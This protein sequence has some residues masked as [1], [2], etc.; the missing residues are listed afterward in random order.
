[1][2]R[3]FAE[4][5]LMLAFASGHA[6]AA[7]IEP[8]SCRNGLFPNEQDDLHV[9]NVAGAKEERLAFYQD[10]QGCPDAGD[11][12]KSKAYVLPGDEVIVNKVRGEWACAWFAGKKHETVGW[13][14]TSRLTSLPTE[15]PKSLGAWTGRWTESPGEG[16]IEITIVGAKLHIEGNTTWYGGKSFDGYPVVHTGDLDG[17]MS[18]Q[19]NMAQLTMDEGPYACQAKFTLLGKYLI[20]ADNGNCGGVNVKFD[21]VYMK[22][23]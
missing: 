13:V 4:G 19:S 9:A 5:L 22:K 16:V 15:V 1:M 23:Q 8:Y 14:R 18:P 11:K 7:T 2:M 12:C 17:D 10:N 3:A 20:V 6:S 21:G